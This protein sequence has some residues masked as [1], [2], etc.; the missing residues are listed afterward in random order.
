MTCEKVAKMEKKNKKKQH[1][2]ERKKILAQT[3]KRNKDAICE[4][5]RIEITILRLHRVMKNISLV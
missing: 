5:L 4:H 1:I 3:L 2:G